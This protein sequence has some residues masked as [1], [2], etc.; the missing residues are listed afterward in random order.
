MEET[1]R[2]FDNIVEVLR[3]NSDHNG[4]KWI[5]VLSRHKTNQILV[6]ILSRQVSTVWNYLKGKERKGFVDSGANISQDTLY[7]SKY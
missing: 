7:L 6:F 2:V 1:L 4:A 3:A 5:C